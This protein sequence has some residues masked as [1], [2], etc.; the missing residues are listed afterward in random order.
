MLERFLARLVE[1][2]YEDSFVLDEK[3]CK[4]VVAEIAAA[5]ADDG[6]VYDAVPTRIEQIRDEEE[7]SAL[8][9]HVKAQL[10]RAQITVKLDTSTGDPIS[11]HAKLVTMP[12]ILGGEFTLMG[13][14]PET[15][16]PEKA[17]S[18]LQR[19]A[20]STRRRDYIDVRSHAAGAAAREYCV[21]R[22]RKS[23]SIDRSNFPLLRH[24]SPDIPR[25]HSRSG[26]LGARRRTSKTSP[27]PC[28]LMSSP[29]L[30]PS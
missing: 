4:Q 18:I 7:Y 28:A 21:R 8:R 2:L 20:T 1:S 23:R 25:S 15:V 14:P 6:V 26:Q 29:K 17:E 9:V 12:R 5:K 24:R 10:Y 27:G 11:P 22:S 13:H 19:V 30:R 3:L 16:I